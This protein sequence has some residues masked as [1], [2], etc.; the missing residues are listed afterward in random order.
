MLTRYDR[1]PNITNF[2]SRLQD[3]QKNKGGEIERDGSLV[4]ERSH[5]QTG[6]VLASAK[7][8]ELVGGNLVLDCVRFIH[9]EDG[10]SK[11]TSRIKNVSL[12]AQC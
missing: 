7:T 12:K 1:Y 11:K 9:F 6:A 10:L 3:R 5:R 2:V 8:K 4:R